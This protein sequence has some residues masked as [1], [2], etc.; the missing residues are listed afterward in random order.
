MNTKVMAQMPA[1][2]AATL[3]PMM[4]AG[5]VADGRGVPGPLTQLASDLLANGCHTPVV[6]YKDSILDG[7]NRIAAAQIVGIEELPYVEYEG[8]DPLMYVI[9]LN[10]HRRHLTTDQL[11]DLGA[12]LAV[13]FEGRVGTNQWVSSDE[14]TLRG[15]TAELVA[16]ALG[17]AVSRETLKRGWAVQERSPELWRDVQRGSVSVSGAYNKLQS[18]PP[19]IIKDA[20]Q[21]LSRFE[22]AYLRMIDCIDDLRKADAN[23]EQWNAARSYTRRLVEEAIRVK[24]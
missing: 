14:P 6:I 12:K 10:L 17:G 21:I 19:V 5:A 4:V 15:T 24:P 7:R 9:S 18:P 1:H 20:E 13:M 11:V 23:D 3:F 8:T 16:E 22:A 2:E